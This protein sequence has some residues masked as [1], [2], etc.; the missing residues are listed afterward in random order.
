M[1][2]FC[3]HDNISWLVRVY[4][5]PSAT[6]PESVSAD[7]IKELK[8]QNKIA[9]S[10]ELLDC[11]TNN[12]IPE[13][14]IVPLDSKLNAVDTFTFHKSANVSLF[15]TLIRRLTNRLKYG[16]VSKPVLSDSNNRL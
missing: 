13:I 5:G 15:T 11:T 14:L 1:L 12:M 9:E 4:T 7:K 3:T 8:S 6:V 10:N 16:M 2:S